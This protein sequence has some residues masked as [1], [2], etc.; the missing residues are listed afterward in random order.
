MNWDYLIV[1]AG[2]AGCA[3]AYELVRSGRKVLLVEAGGRDRSLFIKVAAAQPQACARHDWG[4]W[5]QPDPSRNGAT[6]NWVRGRVLGGSSSINGTMYTRGTPADFD[7]WNVPGWSGQDVLPIFREFENSDQSG[8]LRG[9]SGPLHIRTV[10]HPHAIT[11]AFVESAR[12]AGHPFNE[13]Y[14]GERQEGVSYAQLSQ[15]RGWRCSA[16]DA[17]LK[18]LRGKKNLELVLDATVE[19]IEF[20]AGRAVGVRFVQRGKRRRETAHHIILCAGVINT[21]QLLML[22]GI[23][24]PAELE[25]HDI[26]VVLELRGVGRQLKEQPMLRLA[27]RTKTPSYNLTEGPL[28]KLGIAAKFL[29]R[30]EGP[31]SNLF[32][33][34]AFLKSSA[35]EPVPDLQ[36][37]FMPME[38]LKLPG[39]GYGLAPYPSVSVLILGSFPRSRG[40]VRL[41]ID[42]ASDPPRI[43]CRLLEE[44]ADVDTLVRG[45][46]EIR[47]IMSTPPIANLVSEETSPGAR[48]AEPS[49]LQ[50]HVRDHAGISLHPIG[51]CRMGTDADS[52]VGPDL[53]VH[54]TENLWIA[55]ASIIPEHMSA[56]MNAVCILIGL[57]LGKQLT[58]APV[59]RGIK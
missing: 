56:N 59:Q 23:G 30:G 14:N 40:R 15:R 17:F 34:A 12:A 27:Y 44:Q 35:A 49:A 26:A 43:E 1:G 48:I 51:T 52:V 36:V 16:A 54:G 19:K 22:S 58:A 21:P 41:A 53:R 20:D 8:A 33:A 6:E 2:S 10:R 38:Y 37:I 4:Y 3:L 28:Q 29:A 50:E 46:G 47:R 31:I 57:K 45:I 55:D 9:H 25:R 18:P 7:R 24:D 11:R 32:E 13:D 42:N 39:G 5:S